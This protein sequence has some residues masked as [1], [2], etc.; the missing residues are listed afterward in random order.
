[1]RNNESV[2]NEKQVLC[3]PQAT[4]ATLTSGSGTFNVMLFCSC[5]LPL[6][7]TSHYICK[8]P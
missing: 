4:L 2:H 5:L 1:M 7:V 6:A 8:A 3:E